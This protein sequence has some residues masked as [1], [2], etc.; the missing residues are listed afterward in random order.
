MKVGKTNVPHNQKIVMIYGDGCMLFAKQ[1]ITIKSKRGKEEK[2]EVKHE[3][4]EG[5]RGPQNHKKS[6]RWSH[7]LA[8]LPATEA[9]SLY[10]APL[11]TIWEEQS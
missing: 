8:V 10:T 2:R 11:L 7:P 5:V 3:A 6:W 1:S 4:K 9:S